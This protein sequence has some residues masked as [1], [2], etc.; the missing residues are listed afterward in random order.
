MINV[1]TIAAAFA[2][3]A[4]VMGVFGFWAQQMQ[5]PAHKWVTIGLY[6]S[7]LAFFLPAAVEIMG[8]PKPMYLEFLRGGET[9]VIAFVSNQGESIYLWLRAPGD[10]EPIAYSLPWSDRLARS[11]HDL[12]GNIANGEGVG[13]DLSYQYS[14]DDSDVLHPLPQLMLPPKLDR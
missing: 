1:E 7:C 8:R 9:E 13:I 3:Q 2:V 14:W 12:R 5:R 11:L 6:V 4:V 10:P